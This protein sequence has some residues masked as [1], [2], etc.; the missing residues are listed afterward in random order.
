MRIPKYWAKEIYS[1][2]DSAGE[3]VSATCWRGS[4]ISV[5][6]ARQQASIGAKQIAWKIANQQQLNRYDY[7]ERPLREEITQAITNSRGQEIALV[8]RNRYGALVLNAANVMFIDI[9]FKEPEQRGGLSALFGKAA[10]TQEEKA[11]QQIEQ[12]ARRQPG[13]GL[14]VYRT[15]GGLRGLVTSE[16]FD[17]TVASSLE[18]LKSLNSDPLYIQLCRSQGCFRARLTPKP[19]RCGV[20]NPPA[21]FPWESNKDEFTYRQWQ[22]DYEHASSQYSVCRLIKE[23][24]NPA[25]HP[26]VRQIIA[27]HDEVAWLPARPQLA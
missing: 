18:I 12:W 3:T 25:A 6:D 22:K 20:G 7:G 8:T 19:W 1:L 17:P 11:I 24:G 13:I 21:R 23:I 2:Q 4:E 5:E 9:D 10:P 26:E 14:R 16:L 27:Y 15:F